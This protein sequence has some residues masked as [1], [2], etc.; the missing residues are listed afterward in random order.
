MATA[1]NNLSEANDIFLH[2]VA[3]DGLH[4]KYIPDIKAIIGE[5]KKQGDN[6]EKERRGNAK[7]TKND[8]NF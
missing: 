1:I 5:K 8:Y 3:L 7:E 2:L 6:E 4:A